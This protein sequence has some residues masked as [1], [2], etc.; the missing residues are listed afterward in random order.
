MVKSEAKFKE[1]GANLTPV[2]WSLETL[3]KLQVKINDIEKYFIFYKDF[4]GKLGSDLIYGNTSPDK[5]LSSMVHRAIYPLYRSIFKDIEGEKINIA[6][7]TGFKNIMN[8]HDAIMTI[9][10]K[11]FC[12]HDKNSKTFE[13]MD[14]SALLNSGSSIIIQSFLSDDE[15]EKIVNF[16]VKDILSEI[17]N[18]K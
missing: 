11:D 8:E 6:N 9:V 13:L 16:L 3:V 12:H 4:K 2:K 5:I 18:K 14:A 17:I 15:L 10:D 7:F 1:T